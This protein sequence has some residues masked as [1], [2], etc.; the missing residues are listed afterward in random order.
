M[1]RK[2][3]KTDEMPTTGHEWDGIR[4][5]DTPMPRWWIWTFYGTVVW[6][7][8]IVIA[9][10][11]IPLINSA[12]PGLLGYSTRGEVAQEIAAAAE[13]NAPLYASIMETPLTEI[14]QDDELASFV[15]SSGP[16]AFSTYCAQCHGSGAQ[17]GPGYPNL[18]DDAWLWGG[19]IE[20]IHQTI[21]HGIRDETDPETR[22]SQMP[23]FGENWLEASEIEQVV[24]YVRQISGQE[25]DAEMAA[26][27]AETFTAECTA[28]HGENAQGDAALGA[29]NLTDAVWLFGGDRETLIRTITDG[30]A[31]MMPAW[32]ERLQPAQIRLI[33]AYVHQLGGGQ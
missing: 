7:I 9:Y 11:A 21:A 2:L 18:L 26:A 1:A 4:E 31:G 33:A 12:T 10:P 20:A 24:E 19:D 13:A 32:V 15:A 16:L 14:A 8:G 3:D 23:G 5:Y 28:C 6:S 25:H 29:P 22:F 30:R 17:G 27:G